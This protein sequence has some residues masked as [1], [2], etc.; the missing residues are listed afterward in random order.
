MKKN[1]LK[2]TRKKENIIIPKKAFIPIIC[3]VPLTAIIISKRDVGA[4]VVLIV[5]VT[6]GIFIGKG[7][8][9]K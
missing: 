6:A 7:F 2:G 4:L 9:E 3:I 5:G 8:F 1:T